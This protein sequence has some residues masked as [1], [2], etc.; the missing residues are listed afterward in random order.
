MKLIVIAATTVISGIVSG[1][2]MT[3]GENYGES[4][5][6]DSPGIAFGLTTAAAFFYL[7]KTSVIKLII[8]AITSW[9]SWRVALSLYLSL[10]QELS[11]ESFALA[12]LVVPGIV[13]ASLLGLLF[14]GLIEKSSFAKLLVTAIAGAFGAFGMYL[15][16]NYFSKEG[17]P[18]FIYSFIIWQVLVGAALVLDNTL[19][20]Q[21]KAKK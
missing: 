7:Y 4:A 10:G 14:W 20:Q 18:A 13:G 15:V 6:F 9:L 11:L 3:N 16:F 19:L 8:W 21:S 12:Q 1:Y 5:V 2:F 17:T